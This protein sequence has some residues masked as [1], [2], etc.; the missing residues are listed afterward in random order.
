MCIGGIL[1]SLRICLW[2]YLGSGRDVFIQISLSLRF[3]HKLVNEISIYPNRF[4]SIIYQK[5]P[6]RLVNIK[7][8]SNAYVSTSR[9]TWVKTNLMTSEFIRDQQKLV[10]ELLEH[11]AFNQSWYTS[12]ALFLFYIRWYWTFK[13]SPLMK[14]NEN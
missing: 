3:T 6:Y 13:H 1:R 14:L 4:H 12:I 7:L 5:Y 2:R 11:M 8:C 9:I 10:S